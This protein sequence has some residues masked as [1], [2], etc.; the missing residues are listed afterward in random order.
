MVVNFFGLV[1]LSLSVCLPNVF[2][3]GSNLRLVNGL[4]GA[5]CY[6]IVIYGRIRGKK[7]SICGKLAAA[8]FISDVQV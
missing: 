8:G 1:L 7:R 6:Y 5:L 4:F 2:L 3:D